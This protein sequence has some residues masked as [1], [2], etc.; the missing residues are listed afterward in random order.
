MNYA[1]LPALHGLDDVDSHA[2]GRPPN[3]MADRHAGIA[4]IAFH[5]TDLPTVPS[6]QPPFVA[7][8][9]RLPAVLHQRLVTVK[10]RLLRLRLRC[11]PPLT[12]AEGCAVEANAS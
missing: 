3:A 1:L 5:S 10:P 11:G 8:S 7:I 12:V 6:L 2:H 4:K 9:D